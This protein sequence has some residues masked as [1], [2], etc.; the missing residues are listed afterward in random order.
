MTTHLVFTCAH[1]H[2]DFN[3][4][5]FTWLGRLMMD[6]KPDVVV[7][8]GDMADMP[9]LCSYDFG[10]ASF[11]GRRYT[12]DI[13][14]NIDANNKLFEP[15][16]DYNMQQR[17]NKKI[18]YRPKRVLLYGNHEQRIVTA[19][20]RDPK[21]QGVIGLKDLQN[22]RY[23]WETHPF[24]DVVCIDGVYY[25]HYFVSGVMGRPISGEHTSHSLVTKKFASCTQGHVHTR[26]FCERTTP[27]GKRI[28]ALVAGCYFD[29]HAD[30]AGTSNSM[31]WRGV[32]IKRKVKDG[33]YDHEWVSMDAIKEEYGK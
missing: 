3:N 27:D 7:N 32:V 8:L 20:D 17:A 23:G 30:Y 16:A 25:S 28:Q 12:K 14:A 33:T 4:D 18:T 21:L 22:E 6:V 24:L 13:Q 29:Y 10:K 15:M 5:R 1:A 9:S 26:D 19:T 2:P 31:Y 11:E